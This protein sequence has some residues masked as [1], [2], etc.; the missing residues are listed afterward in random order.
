[1]PNGSFSKST[2]MIGLTHINKSRGKNQQP[3]LHLIKQEEPSFLFHL[4]YKEKKNIMSTSESKPDLRQ[5]AQKLSDSYYALL[6]YN[7]LSTEAV[8]AHTHV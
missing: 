2:T 5:T 3:K 1:M 8:R 6:Q 7:T 4:N